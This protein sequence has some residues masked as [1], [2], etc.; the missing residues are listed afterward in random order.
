M[1][2]EADTKALSTNLTLTRRKPGKDGWPHSR[3][4][5]VINVEIRD[6]REGFPRSQALPCGERNNP[7][8][9]MTKLDRCGDL[10]I[11]LRPVAR[12]ISRV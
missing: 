1:S 12:F 8:K 7:N 3:I 11:G 5:G 10:G 9:K 6:V 2:A 4:D